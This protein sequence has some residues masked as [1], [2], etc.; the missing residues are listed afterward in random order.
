MH[1]KAGQRLCRLWGGTQRR[2]MGE[3]DGGEWEEF[4][5]LDIHGGWG[6]ALLDDRKAI[7]KVFET[8]NWGVWF[9]F[10]FCGFWLLS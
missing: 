2:Y 7:F 8:G 6:F 3:E 10:L 1:F 4:S 5:H 9:C